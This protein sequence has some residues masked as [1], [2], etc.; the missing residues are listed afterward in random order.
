[1][2][3]VLKDSTIKIRSLFDTTIGHDI[4]ARS[5]SMYCFSR[6]EEWISKS[7]NQIKPRFKCTAVLS[8]WCMVQC[9]EMVRTSLILQHFHPSHGKQGSAC[10]SLC[11]S[12]S[13]VSFSDL[14]GWNEDTRPCLPSVLS[15]VPGYFW[16]RLASFLLPI[17]A[18]QHKISRGRVC[19]ST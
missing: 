18:N 19:K 14:L 8:S 7:T 4:S 10:E 13:P 2:E 16:N 12:F 6:K 15:N 17:I 3:F 1:M 9:S 5:D 11:E